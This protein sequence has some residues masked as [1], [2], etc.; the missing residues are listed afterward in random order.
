MEK[1]EDEITKEMISYLGCP[2]QVFPPD[3][4]TEDLMAAY[5]QARSEGEKEGF[6][7]VMVA[8]EDE[9]LLE[10]L[11]MN[12]RGETVET[13]RRRILEE[14]VEEGR[15]Y[16][17][18]MIARWKERNQ[19]LYDSFMGEPEE[20]CY[21][22]WMY[23]FP[24]NPAQRN[25]FG[26]VDRRMILARI[27][28][29]HPWEIFAY[30]PFGGWNDCPDT[31]GLMAAAKH[32]NQR[33]GAVPVSMNHDCLE[34]VVPSPVR[35]KDTAMLTVEQFVWCMDLEDISERREHLARYT[36]WPFWWD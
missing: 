9:I 15:I 18:R 12:L 19:K 30:L 8:A 29:E 25:S 28:V 17:A 2:C 22:S 24:G 33:Y 5:R 11:Q 4:K 3:A 26:N 32:W 36:V 6:W 16:F 35:R 21:P 1:M 20:G 7:P 23:E 10:T 31:P 14:P 27:P 34:F 13:Y